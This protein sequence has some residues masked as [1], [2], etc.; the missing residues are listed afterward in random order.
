MLAATTGE[1][2]LVIPVWGS[3]LLALVGVGYL[4]FGD[5]LRRFFDV[6]SMTVLGC[7]VGLIACPWVPLPQPIVIIVG[8]LVLGGLAALFRNV[9][10]SLL[11]AVVLGG[12]LALLAA[13]AVGESGWAKYLA[14]NVKSYSFQ[15]PGPNLSDDRVLAAGVTGFLAG[16]TVAVWRLAFSER[17]ITCVQGAALIA[18]GI[19]TGV[20]TYRGEAQQSLLVA[21]PFTLGA[22]WLC[23]VVIGLVAQ[24]ELARARE[25]WR[26]ETGLPPDSES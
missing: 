4:I 16:V 23:L 14:D 20:T 12:V 6:L 21:Y 1:L 26:G 22:V 18:L 5:W 2:R 17:L 3:I 8:G 7:V 9:G 24:S 25:R 11:A 19:A 13:L 10:H 15:L